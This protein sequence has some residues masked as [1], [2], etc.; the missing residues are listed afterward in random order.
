[1]L[2]IGDD[3][4]TDGTLQVKDFSTGDQETVDRELFLKKLKVRQL[5]R[6]GEG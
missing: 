5:Q 6:K 1:V 2:I 3:E 4:L